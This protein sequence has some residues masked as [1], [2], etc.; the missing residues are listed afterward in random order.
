[1][2]EEPRHLAPISTARLTL[3]PLRANDRVAVARI[4]SCSVTMEKVM[5]GPL[6]AE[7]VAEWLER[8]IIADE[9]R[10]GYSMWG[11]E[12]LGTLVHS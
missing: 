8:R 9:A 4:L 12:R 3:R 1:M 2:G 5:G 10:R 11:M 6:T 7:A